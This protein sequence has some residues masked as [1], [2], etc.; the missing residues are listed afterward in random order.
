MTKFH[1]RLAVVGLSM[2]LFLLEGPLAGSWPVAT[3]SYMFFDTL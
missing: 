3:S 1:L 2:C